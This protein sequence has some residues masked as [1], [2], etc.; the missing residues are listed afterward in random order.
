VAIRG[1]GG[2]E[3]EAA[4]ERPLGGD[5]RRGA[6]G[7]IYPMGHDPRILINI[8]NTMNGKHSSTK[9]QDQQT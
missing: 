8:T 5:D 9:L 7:P 1:K 2:A 3:G 6:I 4:T